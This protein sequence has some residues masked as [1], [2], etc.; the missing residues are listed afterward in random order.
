MTITRRQVLRTATTAVP[1]IAAAA[2]L[3]TTTRAAPSNRIAVGLIGCGKMANDYHLPQLLRQPDVQ[4]VAVCEV[5]RARREHAVRKVENAYS[6]GKRTFQGCQQTFDF[7]ELIGRQDIDAVCIATPDHW[8]ATPLIE[9]CKAGKDVYCE[10]PLT[11]TIAE[12]QR[13]VQAARKFQRIVQTGSQQRSNVFGKFRQAVEIIRS[14]RLGAIHRV[15]VGVGAPSV[16]CDLPAEPLEAGLAWDMWLGQAPSR[17]YH[18]IL[19]PR[20]VH[21]HFPAWR[22]YREY[23]GGGHT[24]MGAHHYDIA[25]WALD[26]DR[27]GPVQIIPPADPEATTGVRYLYANGTEIQHGGPSGCVF[28]GEHGTLR[29]DRGILQSDPPELVGEPLGQDDVHLPV[30]PG[31]H[32]NWLDCI[33]SRKSPVADVEYGARTVTVIHLGNL[34]YAQQRTL[35]W[36]PATWRFPDAADNHLLDR[37]RRDPWQLPQL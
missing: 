2:S 33:R 7:R 35:D 20:G 6:K 17:P 30:S 26:M 34:A 4:L 5:D 12:A 8:H 11:L 37:P 21:N 22:N 29:I 23:S 15:T 27:S 14:G 36:N 19:S 3:G 10:K 28:H 24:D 1:T 25:Q 13:C 18:S 32:R 16:T 9:A 31:H